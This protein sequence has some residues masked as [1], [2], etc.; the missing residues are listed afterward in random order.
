VLFPGFSMTRRRRMRKPL[1][2]PYVPPPST[3]SVTSSITLS[4]VVS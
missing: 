1:D 2:A 4:L 3:L